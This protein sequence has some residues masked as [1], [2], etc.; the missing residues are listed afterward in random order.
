[1]TALAFV[2]GIMPLIFASGNFST[3]RNIMGVA[4]AGGMIVAT[5]VGLLLYPASYYLVESLRLK[6]SKSNTL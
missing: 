2:L 5:S 6:F 3:A 1:M 4:L